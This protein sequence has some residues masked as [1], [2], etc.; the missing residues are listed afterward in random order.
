MAE[1][2]I[3]L[4]INAVTNQDVVEAFGETL[5]KVLGGSYDELIKKLQDNKAAIDGIN[6]S[7]KEGKMDAD[8]AAKSIRQ[9]KAE[10]ANYQRVLNNT[11]KITKAV[12]GSQKQQQLIL[13]KVNMGIR[14]MTAEQKK[15][16]PELIKFQKALYD[17]VKGMNAEMG[18]FQMNVGNYPQLLQQILPVQGQVSNQLMQMAQSAGLS[19]GALGALGAA[20]G[21]GTLAYKGFQQAMDLTQTVGDEVAIKMAGWESVWDKFIRTVVSADF[22]NFLQGL[23]DAKQAGEELAASLD[24]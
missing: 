8:V 5:D 24:E 12:N 1:K 18:N 13:E 6:K 23:R 2:D 10:N 17:S 20:L 3:I 15:A 22:T 19:T 4:R 7:V 14:N 16:N 9:L 21:V 11:D